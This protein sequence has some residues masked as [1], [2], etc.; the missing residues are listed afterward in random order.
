MRLD[1]PNYR[2][3]RSASFSDQKLILIDAC[4][5][6]GERVA[7]AAPKVSFVC[8]NSAVQIFVV[9]H[10]VPAGLTWNN[11]KVRLESMSLKLALLNTL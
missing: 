6:L 8:L 5:T 11:P 1:R 2:N 3:N 9:L 7:E 4:M 10:V